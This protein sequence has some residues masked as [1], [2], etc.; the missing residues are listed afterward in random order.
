[1]TLLAF[2]ALLDIFSQLML[3]LKNQMFDFDKSD[4]ESE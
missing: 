3:Y 4:T 2:K 1:M